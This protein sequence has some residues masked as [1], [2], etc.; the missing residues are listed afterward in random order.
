MISARALHYVFKIGNRAKNI[1]FFRE[2]LGM[3]VLR[4]EEFTQGCDAACNGPYDNRWS[5]T[6]IGYGPEASHF[7][8]ELTYNYG[9]K[10]YA[11]GNDFAGLTIASPEILE[12]AR[13]H[14]Y[15]V[16][17]GATGQPSLLRSPDGYRVFVV[18]EPT[19]PDADPV[20]RVALNVTDLVR[21]RHYWADTLTMVPTGNATDPNRANL[22]YDQ[23]KFVLELR[24][25]DA[26][27]ALNRAKAYGR[28]A[29]AVPYDVQP[30]I[31][32][33][34]QKANGT[35]L[36]PLISLDT[37]GKATVRVLIL[38]DPDGHEICFVDEEGFSAL[39]VLDPDSNAALD[40]YIAKDPMPCR[41]CG[42]DC[43]CLRM[44]SKRSCGCRPCDS[45]CTCSCNTSSSR[46]LNPGEVGSD[47]QQ[48]GAGQLTAS[49]GGCGCTSG[50]QVNE[51]GTSA[52][53][54]PL[55]HRKIPCWYM[56]VFGVAAVVPYFYL[57]YDNCL[58]EVINSYQV[59]D[60]HNRAW[61]QR[62]EQDVGHGSRTRYILLY[63]SFFKEKHWGL[64][65]ETLGPDYFAQKHCPVKDCVLTSYH[66]LLPSL[67]EYDALVFHVASRWDGPLPA[68]RSPHQVYVAALME[69][70]A[71]TKHMLRLD[72]DYFNWTMTYR[73]DSDVLFNYMNVVDLES[74]QVI[75]PALSPAWRNGH[76]EYSNTTLAEAVARKH[77]MAAQFV[78][79]CGALSGRDRLVK[80]MQSVGFEVDVYGTCGPLSC[81]RGKPECNQML[82]TVYWFYLSFENSLCVDY[83]TEKLYNALEHNIVPI[84][85]GG[86]D[87][88]R[89]MPP[90]SYINV[91]DYETV[92]K[93][94]DYLQHL[95]NNPSEYVKY[96]WWKQYYAL[97]YIN[98]YCDLC[99][100]L[101]SVDARE[102]VQYYRNI[103]NWWY[104]DACT[105]KPKIEF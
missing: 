94:V 64:Q 78:S 27:Q 105:A 28:I 60:D 100:K 97:E 5:K 81:P 25:L 31:D 83:V 51:D 2:I 79:H 72:G 57:V 23:G 24:Q 76:Q 10:E 88:D 26:G 11:L 17:E 12:R 3:K 9:V 67:T 7:V 18:P 91:Q 61:A 13:A 46:C 21:S 63:T 90:G 30:R 32:E 99:V 104:D 62:I 38:A 4:H 16:E 53:M 40:K 39:S 59:L 87:Y 19:A 74:G 6:M 92:D 71:H 1:H 70:P 85:F 37:P 45:G 49:Q 69:S 101:H 47:R 20:R 41:T 22:S 55:M 34:I 86:A 82:D 58:K 44:M 52:T 77:K 96:F 35:I 89:F 80:K 98:S 14:G 93:L 75:S 66:Q 42:K 54:A 73:L 84:V 36:T 43:K 103:K 50:G 56:L 29:F 8:I 65:A 102:R 33:L 48:E 68:V 95:V 15:P